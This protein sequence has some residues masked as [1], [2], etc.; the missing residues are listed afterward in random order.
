M[1]LEISSA[2]EY[3]NL[4]PGYWSL[5]LV[6]VPMTIPSHQCYPLANR[7]PARDKPHPRP[8]PRTLAGEALPRFG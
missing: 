7:L 8:A 2:F 6:G 3:P 5:G 4:N 1:G